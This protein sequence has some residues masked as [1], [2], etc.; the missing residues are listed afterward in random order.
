MSSRV[1]SLT[2][3]ELEFLKKERFL[4]WGENTED[5]KKKQRKIKK[6]GREAGL[7][8]PAR[9]NAVE[10]DVAKLLGRQEIGGQMSMTMPAN[11]VTSSTSRLVV[12]EEG[13]R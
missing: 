10:P 13:D 3:A 9:K 12:S 11:M 2:S 7:C 5:I 8:S 4:Q 6:E 1:V